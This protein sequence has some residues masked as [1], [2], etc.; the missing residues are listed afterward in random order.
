MI[1]VSEREYRICECAECDN[2]VLTVHAG[3]AQPRCHG[4]EMSEVTDRDLSVNPPELRQVLLDAFGLPKVGI[5]VRL[6][7]IGEGRM[8]PAE[9]ADRLDYDRSTISKYLDQLVDVGILEKSQLNR[10]RG[11]YVNL[12]HGRDIERLRRE[13]LLGFYAWAGEAAVLIEEANEAKAQYIEE[14]YSETFH[15]LFWEEFRKESER[16][17]PSGRRPFGPRPTLV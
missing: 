16:P 6:C 1:D 7:V 5:D 8:S 4:S 3:E 9:V 2:A 15:E 17:N 14:N 13:I 11:G 10:K 12:Y